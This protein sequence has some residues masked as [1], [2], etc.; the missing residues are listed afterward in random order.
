M[1][2]ETSLS[3]KRKDSYTVEDLEEGLYRGKDVKE[4]VLR[5]KERVTLW[6][7]HEAI[8]EIFGE[9]LAG[10]KDGEETSVH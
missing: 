6:E 1:N 3:D 10:G 4:A 9:K 7:I 8:D 5:L 2:K